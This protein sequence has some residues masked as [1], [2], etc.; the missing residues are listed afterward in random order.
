MLRLR[1]FKRLYAVDTFL[2]VRP[3]LLTALQKPNGDKGDDNGNTDSD[4]DDDLPLEIEA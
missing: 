2:H 4:N 3:L 1:R